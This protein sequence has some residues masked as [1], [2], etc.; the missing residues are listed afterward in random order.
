M[1]KKYKFTKETTNLADKTLYR[2]EALKDFS[3]VK[4]GDKGGFIENEHNLSQYGDAWIGNNAK[5]FEDA[6]VY[7][8]ADVSDCA[9]V[10]GNAQVFGDAEVFGNA[11]VYSR[12]HI[13]SNACISSVDDFFVICSIG[14]R[15]DITFYKTKDN[16]IS[17]SCIWFNG[18]IDEFLKKVDEIHGTDKYVKE[19]YAAADRARIRIK[20]D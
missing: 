17:V 2:I 14:H 18:S 8:N 19:Y 12:S 4:K 20:L 7:G 13:S 9:Y 5:V 16:N 10:F 3:D 11:E 15:G 6:R 1:G